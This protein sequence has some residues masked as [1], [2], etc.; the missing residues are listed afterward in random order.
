MMV[1]G[2]TM[3][4]SDSSKVKKKISLKDP[5]DG[6]FDLSQFLLEANGV[7][8][9]IIP[10]TEPAVGYGAGAAI[11]YFHKRKKEY[12]TY[13]PPNVSG[14][15]GFY[16]ENKTW[17]AGAFHSH[18]FGENRVRT[19][20]AFFKPDLRIKY[21]GNGSEILANNPIGINLDS[22]VFMQ[23][24]EVRLGKSKFYAGAS[25]TYFKTNVSFDTIPDR[26]ILNEIIKRLNIN[27]T[28]SA[29]KPHVTFDS[30]N[31]AFT[32]TKGIK[33]EVATN[34]SAEWLGSSD[35]FSTLHTNFLGYLPV[36]SRFNSA[37]RFEGSYLLG[38][39]PFYAYPFIDLRGIAAMRYQG[40]NVMVTETEWTYNVYNRW[41]LLGFV[42]GGKAF[43]EFS[44]FSESDWAYTLGTG[45][46]YKIARLLGVNMGADFAWG[47]GEDF[48]FYIVFGSAWL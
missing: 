17:G 11:L 43:S 1:T 46:R 33:G 30:R 21:F 6:A 9:V 39:A 27:S 25:Y 40:D 29:I 8:P 18:I 38:D 10:I 48:A 15:M 3:G 22:W 44:D 35:N 47:N 41:S 36:S 4:Q 37:W 45:F 16:T 20:T 26:P 2:F 19:I 13:V 5:E 7:L 28:I 31:N 14:I 24:G 34:F 32:P 23:K 42:G 12:A